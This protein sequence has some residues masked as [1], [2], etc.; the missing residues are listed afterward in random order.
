VNAWYYAHLVLIQG[1][2]VSLLTALSVQI[3]I[4]VGVFSFAG[5]GSYAIGAYFAAI[6]VLRWEVPALL[7]I[8]GGAAIAAVVGYLLALL[9]ARLDG[10]YLGMATIASVLI[11]SV[12]AINGGDITG[13]SNGLF[14]AISGFR[15]EYL[16]A[17]AVVVVVLLALSERGRLGRKIDVVRENPEL[18]L[19]MGISVTRV[20]RVAF[21]VSGLLGACAGAMN[22]LLRTTVTPEDVSFH[23]V[24]I[25]L[26]MII[27]GGYRSWAGVALG[28]VVFTWLPEVLASLE[29]WQTVVY[30]V[31]VTLA[32]VWVPD[33]ILGLLQ[34]GW[35][36][37]RSRGDRRPPT[38]EL[39]AAEPGPQLLPS[40]TGAAT[41]QEVATTQEVAP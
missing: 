34:R 40:F 11:L 4:R 41:K 3:P 2:F 29:S 33:G 18:A 31:I 27:V 9:L 38:D 39:A 17:F 1:T 19:S 21:V 32:A 15:T 23:L 16:I 22:A 36:A 37:V 35:R 28:V 14:G 8:L 7:A 30:G 5:I 25:I 24:V 20:R 26:T 12:I 6:S 13:A 10:L